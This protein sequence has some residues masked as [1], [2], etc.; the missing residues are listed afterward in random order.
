MTLPFARAGDP[1]IE[2]AMT[3]PAARRRAKSFGACHLLL[4]FAAAALRGGKIRRTRCKKR[5]LPPACWAARLR[6]RQSKGQFVEA[7]TAGWFRT[8]DLLFHRQALI[9]L[10]KQYGKRSAIEPGWTVQTSGANSHV[11]E[12]AYLT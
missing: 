3:V 12:K 6:G 11:R 1:A 8:T 9:S 5:R 2:L 10:L 4:N 7:G